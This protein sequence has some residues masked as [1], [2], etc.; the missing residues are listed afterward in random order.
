M[1]TN[2][3]VFFKNNH[4]IAYISKNFLKILKDDLISKVIIKVDSLNLF[5]LKRVI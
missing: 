2:V 4:K 5:D 3:I 1:M